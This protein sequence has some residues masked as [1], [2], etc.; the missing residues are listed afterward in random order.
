[1]AS[2]SPRRKELLAGLDVDFEVRIIKGIDESYPITLPT[3][4]IAEYIAQKKAAAYRETMAADELIITADTI[5]VL[6]DEVLGKPKDAADAHRM[7]HALSGKTHQVVT[8]V[9]LTTKGQ[10]EHFSVVSNVTF[11]ELTD[12]E[13]NYYVE[14]YKPMDKAGAY[15]IQEWI[16]Y[17]GV[18]RLEGS[19]FNVMGLPVQRIYEALKRFNVSERSEFNV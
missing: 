19:Y 12:D 8:G 17:V 15:G 1:L 3:T 9:V 4:E 2:N 18:T 11:K 14:T 13:I 5:V 10:Q 7:L 16:G 6:N